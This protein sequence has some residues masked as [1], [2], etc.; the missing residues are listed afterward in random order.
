MSVCQKGIVRRLPALLRERSGEVV[1]NAT[2][3]HYLLEFTDLNPERLRDTDGLSA[4]VVAAPLESPLRRDRSV[5]SGWIF[6]ILQPVP[7][8]P[9]FQDLRSQSA[10]ALP[11]DFCLTRQ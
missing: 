10:G 1:V 3:N 2:F 11:G 7:D 8:H 4:L 9:G 6:Q 5:V